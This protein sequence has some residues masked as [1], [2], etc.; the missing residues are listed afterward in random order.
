MRI[1]ICAVGRLRGGPE[2]DLIA[3]WSRRLEK[4]GRTLGLGPIEIVEIDDRKAGSPLAEAAALQ[5]A[6]P[7]RAAICALDE[8]G[9][10]L[11]SPEFASMLAGWRDEGRSSTAFLIGGADGLTPA[12][13]EAADFSLSLG[14]MVWPHML[15][16]VM[17]TEQLYRAATILAGMP[18]H[19]H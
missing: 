15:A 16:R 13:V 17:L 1:R 12:L 11:A 5:R 19:R 18:Y 10:Q 3:D 2:L 7:E 6:I 4:T 14:C 8:R 9:R